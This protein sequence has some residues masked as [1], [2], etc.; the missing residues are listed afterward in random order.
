[1]NEEET[2]KNIN[3]D[4]QKFLE[5]GLVQNEFLLSY[6]LQGNAY[7]SQNPFRLKEDSPS[8]RNCQYQLSY[9]SLFVIQQECQESLIRGK[10]H[11]QQ[12]WNK[13]LDYW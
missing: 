11:S 13:E 6:K 1:M 5:L 7:E 9:P 3:K 12:N 8:L 10:I 4:S 2:A